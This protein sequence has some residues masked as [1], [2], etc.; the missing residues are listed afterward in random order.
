MTSKT[1]V[2]VGASRGIGKALV[3][4]FAKRDDFKIIALSRNFE[5]L[6]RASRHLLAKRSLMLAAHVKTISTPTPRERAPSESPSERLPSPHPRSSCEL[7]AGSFATA[8]RPP[9]V[10]AHCLRAY[11]PARPVKLA[12]MARKRAQQRWRRAADA[13]C[14]AGACYAR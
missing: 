1:V 6:R 14:Q 4:N 7:T 5:E 3:E 2:I 8:R 13:H 11:Q 9:G 12:K 10:P